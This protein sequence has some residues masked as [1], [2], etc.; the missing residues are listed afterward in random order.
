MSL[1]VWLPL[2]GH[3][4]NYGLSNIST[5]LLNNPEI[6]TSNRGKVYNLNPNNENN[7][8]IELHISDMPHWVQNEFSIAF[9]VYHKDT[10]SRSIFFGSHDF[11]GNYNFNIEKLATTNKL[12]VY[13]EAAP[14]LQISNCIIPENEW[15]H[16][17][18]TKSTTELKIYK[19]GELIYTRAHNSSDLW[20]SSD[21]TRYR[22][23]RDNRSNSTALNG[24]ISDFRIYDHTLSKK[25][26][27]DLACGLI[28]NYSFDNPYMNFSSMV[29]DVSGYGNHGMIYGSSN[30]S[31]DTCKGTYSLYLDGIDSSYENCSYV[32]APLQLS[33]IKNYTFAANIKINTWGKQNSG[34]LCADIN[35]SFPE[36]YI[37]SPCH[38]KDNYFY[39][40]AQNATYKQ[41]LCDDSDLTPGEWI[42]I[43]LTYDGQNIRLYKNGILIRSVSFDESTILAPCNYIFLS[44]SFADNIH[45]VT[46][47]NWS[48]FRIYTTA[49]TE[50][51]I[52]N[53]AKK[54]VAVDKNNNLYAYSFKEEYNIKNNISKTYNV[55]IN[56]NSDSSCGIHESNKMAVYKDYIEVN[57]L[58][59]N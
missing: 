16:I 29:D 51:A 38:H 42:H 54:R 33:E 37:T 36:N 25:E 52:K 59:E 49:L 28:L 45:R 44:Y 14:D 21:S 18:I 57:Q 1:Q 58:Y 46:K 56:I 13:M 48:D 27:N 20:G 53:L 9:W 22:I 5:F 32:L 11:D 12:R 31:Q 23:G 50:N 43:A 30:L 2:N 35:S 15:V 40:A 4:K 34:I 10:A 6:I 19:N 47:A 24:M 55:N 7:Q 8:A 41:L 39:I 17:V 26:I 3:I